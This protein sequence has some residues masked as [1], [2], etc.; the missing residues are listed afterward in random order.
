MNNNKVFKNASWIIGCRIVQSLLQLVIG[1]LTARYLGPSNYGLIN[2]AASI[3]AFA[4]PIMQLGLRNTMIQEFIDTPD[5][6]G[7]IIGTSLGL[8]IISSIACI[9]GVAGFVT[10]A[11]PG[12]P[13]TLIVCVLYA[14][15][16]IFQAVEL[17]Q[18]WFQ[19]KLM[20][21]YPSIMMLIA[22]FAVSAYKVY[23]LATAKDVYWFVLSY[24]IEYGIIGIALVVI[25]FKLGGQGIRFSWK[26]AGRLLAKSRYYIVANLMVTLFANVAQVMLKMMVDNAENGFFAAAVTCTGVTNFVYNAII[27]SMRPVILSAK[28]TDEAAYEKNLRRLYCMMFYLGLAQ[29]VAFCLFA[30]LIVTVLYGAEYMATVPVLQIVVWNVGVSCFGSV[31]NIWILAEGRQKILWFINLSGALVNFAVNFLLIPYFGAIGA[32]ISSVITQIFA[33]FILGFMLPQIRDNN[34]ILLQGIHPR[35]LKDLT[36]SIIKRK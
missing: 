16:L 31:R 18:Y 3:V 2:Y 17:V 10:W 28:Q 22:Y 14:I 4:V 26:M 13:I 6:E 23:L 9:V 5:E 25:Y 20:S 36:K 29:S 27:D 8:G 35:E 12:E 21:K 15:S 1:M 34:R 19:Y 7:V 24:S 33:N 30:K 11:N 32:A